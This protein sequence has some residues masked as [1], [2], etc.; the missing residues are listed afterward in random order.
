[1][2][3]TN[4]VILRGNKELNLLGE[5]YYPN[6]L[7]RCLTPTE[8][9]SEEFLIHGNHVDMIDFDRY[10]EFA[11]NCVMREWESLGLIVNGKPITKKKFKELSDIH[12]YGKRKILFI[13]NNEIIYG[14]YVYETNNVETLYRSYESYLDLFHGN[15]T[16]L[17]RAIIQRG[18]RGIPICGGNLK[19]YQNNF[20]ESKV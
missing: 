4:L 5:P 19:F 13:R 20:V 11:Y 15:T 14:F 17:D 3:K 8:F 10:F 16:Y 2:N 12:T 9:E 1:M 6:R 18:N 7:Y